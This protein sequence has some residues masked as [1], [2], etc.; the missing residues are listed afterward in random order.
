MPHP[1]GKGRLFCD[2]PFRWF[3]V[4]GWY[5]PKGDVFLCCPGWLD[6]P[7]GNILA[8]PI[9][10]IWNGEAARDIRR[11]VLDGSF[12]FCHRE[13]CPNL[14]TASGPVRSQDEVQEP[15]LRRAIE[16]GLHT[17]DWGPQQINCTF[18]IS[19]NLSCPT[20]R[21][22]RILEV[23][24]TATHRRIQQ[25]LQREVLGGA[26]LLYI[27]GAG[28][29]FGSPFYRRWL[30]EMDL[31][32]MPQLQNI[33]LHTNGLLW[34]RRMWHKIPAPVRARIHSAEISIDAASATTYAENRRGGRFD[35]LLKNLDYISSLR[36]RGSL[37]TLIFSMVVQQNNFEEMA[38]FVRL[39]QRHGVDEINF[40]QLSN[41]GTFDA[42]EFRRRAV[43]LPGH[44]RHAEL[45][46]VLRDPIFAAPEIYP[47][48]LGGMVRAAASGHGRTSR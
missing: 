6:R 34:T 44:P 46:A 39:G 29:A 19:C 10:A 20:C 22:R 26:R 17:L 47:G 31:S 8:Q 32:A 41:W 11:S 2:R 9:E 37:S 48:S 1:A 16:Q 36:R 5:Q 27:S 18:D 24:H 7:V 14:Q 40:G 30:R 35:T 33:H 45:L 4:T 28:D 43:H 42:E 13:L 12:E 15:D 38:D 25:V 23:E 21:T 3:E